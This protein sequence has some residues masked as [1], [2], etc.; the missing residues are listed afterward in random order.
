MII[1]IMGSQGSGKSTVLAELEKRGYNTVARKTSRSILAE[2]GVTLNEVNN[3][4]ELTTKF[5]DEILARKRDDDFKHR[6][7]D[8]LWFTERTFADLFTY[9]LIS[10]GKDNGFSQW[11]DQYYVMCETAQSFYDG[12]FYLKGGLF[13]VEHD[14]V[15]GSNQHYARMVDV[16]MSDITTAMTSRSVPLHEV[17]IT[18]LPQR[19]DFIER[20]ALRLVKQHAEGYA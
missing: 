11:L 16:V 7:S 5:Q 8:E 1:A 15:R 9:A 18:D 20:N 17:S 4:P 3:N 10:L 12:I 13:E 19:V 14:G 6:E 2:W